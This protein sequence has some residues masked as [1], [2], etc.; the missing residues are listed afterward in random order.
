MSTARGPERPAALGEPGPGIRADGPARRAV[1]LVLGMI[2]LLVTA[3]VL[4]AVALAVRCSGPGPV[5]FR[6]E[7]VGRGGRSFTILKFRTMTPAPPGTAHLVS[8]ADDPRITRVGRILR[9]TRLDELP[10]L[11]NLLRGDLTLVGPRP[12][13]ARYVRC[14]TARERTLLAVR[15]GL[16]G[17]GALLFAAEQAAE[18]DEVGD[19]ESHYVHQHLRPK[20]ALDLAYLADRRLATDLRV[21]ARA[22]VLIARE[23][24][25][26]V[27][28]AAR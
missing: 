15:P 13:V 16:L 4:L 19:P 10:Q 6:Q 24:W 25:G 23:A 21:V 2:G 1:D 7:R 26:V 20:L 12:E 27:R 8:G 28:G 14:Y 17:P 22:V 5:I 3:P 18:L 9:T 11:I